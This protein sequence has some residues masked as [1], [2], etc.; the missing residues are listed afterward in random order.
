VLVADKILAEGMRNKMPRMPPRA[1]AMNTFRNEA[2]ISGY[3]AWRM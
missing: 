2:V 3:L 1:E